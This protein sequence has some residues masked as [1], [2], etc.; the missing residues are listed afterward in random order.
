MLRKEDCDETQEHSR[1]TIV[2][3]VAIVALLGGM[4]IASTGAIA[5]AARTVVATRPGVKF[6]GIGGAQRL[7]GSSL[8]AR[9]R[10]RHDAAGAG[11]CRAD[12]RNATG[13]ILALGMAVRR[14]RPSS[15]IAGSTRATWGSGSA[16]RQSRW[17]SQC[18]TRCVKRGLLP[19][20]EC[21]ISDRWGYCPKRHVAP[22][23]DPG[24]RSFMCASSAKPG[25]SGKMAVTRE[26]AG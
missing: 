4:P 14:L 24:L 6:T 22:I 20:S 17:R 7:I 11:S 25:D 5:A 23:A 18:S 1:A 19:Y 9:Q 13:L 10:G 8:T 15:R 26:T 2:T 12:G 16:W 21:E 3:L